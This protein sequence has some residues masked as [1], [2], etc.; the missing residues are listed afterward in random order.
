MVR[1]HCRAVRRGRRSALP[2][3]RRPGGGA[4]V[5][6]GG[7]QHRRRRRDQRAC[8]SLP[9]ST[10]SSTRSP[11]RSTLS[12]G[13][14]LSGETWN[15]MDALE[16]YGAVRPASSA[17]AITWFR[18]GDRDL[19]T[20]LYRTARRAEGATLTEI[21]AE[22]AGAWNVGVRVLPMTDGDVSTRLILA[23]GSTLAFQDYF[24]R[25]RHEVEVTAISIETTGSRPT[26]SV[27]AAIENAEIVVIAP[28]NPLVSIQPV[29]VPTGDRRVAD[30]TPRLGRRRVPD[31]RW[32]GPER[33]GRS[34]APRARSRTDRG[35]RRPPVR[36]DRRRPRD[37]S[38]RLRNL[39]ARSRQPASA[40]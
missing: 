9:I 26:A 34:A 1:W 14:G 5:D 35:R 7:G 15:V 27:L 24:V 16:R 17:A 30:A 22:I 36:P 6:H 12:A 38:G 21:T 18:L 37:R 29:R 23:D 25:L 20:H 11:M 28:S 3:G 8:R 19:A 4:V 33:A 39:P 13:W 10:R 2:G 40:P 32:Q 31:R